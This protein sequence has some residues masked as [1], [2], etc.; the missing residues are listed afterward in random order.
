MNELELLDRIAQILD[1]APK[2]F[3]VHRRNPSEP[4]FNIELSSGRTFKVML[5]EAHAPVVGEP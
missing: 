2:G 1:D 4:F 5:I 3:T